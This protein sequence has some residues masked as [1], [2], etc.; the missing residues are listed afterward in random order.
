MT[1]NAESDSGMTAYKQELVGRVLAGAAK[2]GKHL[3]PDDEQLVKTLISEVMEAAYG[4]KPISRK[5]ADRLLNIGLGRLETPSLLDDLDRIASLYCESGVW[6]SC[7][8]LYEAFQGH[9]LSL[10]LDQMY[11]KA[12]SFAALLRYDDADRVFDEMHAE[13]PNAWQTQGM[14]GIILI[15]QGHETDGVMA[16]E[17]AVKACSDGV[18]KGQFILRAMPFFEKAS[19]EP[20]NLALELLD[21]CAFS[22]EDA[23]QVARWRG[24]FLLVV[25]QHREAHE[26]L[27]QAGDWPGVLYDIAL[28]HAREGQWQ[29]AAD[30]FVR[31]IETDPFNAAWATYL[32]A[33]CHEQIGNTDLAA[34]FMRQ[35]ADAGLSDAFQDEARFWLEYTQSR[36]D[37]FAS[38]GEFVCYGPRERILP[39]V[40]RLLHSSETAPP[41][42]RLLCAY[43]LVLSKEFFSC[44]EIAELLALD[45]RLPN[46]SLDF[47][48]E[49]RA[50]ELIRDGE[51]AKAMTI[52]QACDRAGFPVSDSFRDLLQD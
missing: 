47:L 30:A 31:Y 20:A 6:Q 5:T 10:N 41:D 33:L 52:L 44:D 43:R 15:G 35:A 32:M 25:G 8:T 48:L 1:D 4:V 14:R 51:D 17:A 34:D 46:N 37:R 21:S 2:G 19:P 16:I 22:D 28:L 26:W 45:E 7:I 13:A 3:E 39:E 42:K 49:H 27:D 50:W 12:Y 40:E 9:G 36:G 18:A 29:A 38:L 11:R 23:R 24:H